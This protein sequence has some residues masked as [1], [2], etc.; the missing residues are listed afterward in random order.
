M[1][2]VITIITTKKISIKYTQKELRRDQNMS[3]QEINKTQKKVV[4][5]ERKDRKSRR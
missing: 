5:E 3:P 4:R 1:F 2:Y